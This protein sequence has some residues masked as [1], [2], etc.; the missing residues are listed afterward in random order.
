MPKRP[1]S[2]SPITESSPSPSKQQKS[3]PS[4]PKKRPVKRKRE[5]G[6]FAGR[7]LS[8]EAKKILVEEA[9]ALAYR[10]LDWDA[11]SERLGLSVTKLKDQFKPFRANLRKAIEDSF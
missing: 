1:Y 3:T 9:M 11:L 5:R 2:P 4:K 8:Q 6:E 7:R 10:S